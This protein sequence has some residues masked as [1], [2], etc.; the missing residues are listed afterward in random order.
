MQ[1]TCMDPMDSVFNLDE[2]K[3]KKTHP[4]VCVCPSSFP[5]FRSHT[6]K[7]LYFMQNVKHT[8]NCIFYIFYS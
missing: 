5:L 3:K 6:I 2:D 4:H 8:S 1:A 7:H